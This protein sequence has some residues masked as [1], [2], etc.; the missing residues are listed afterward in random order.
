MRLLTAKHQYVSRF[1][2][3]DIQFYIQAADN[4]RSH[5]V[6]SGKGKK[7]GCFF[8]DFGEILNHF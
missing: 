4:L 5:Q 7:D 2:L 1:E 6:I 3:V 8:F